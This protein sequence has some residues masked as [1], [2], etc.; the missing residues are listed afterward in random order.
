MK[1]IKEYIL[2]TIGL[3]FVA[4]GIVYFLVPNDL[5]AGGVS[6]LAMVINYYVPSLSVGT[7]MLIAN[8]VLFIVAFLL[9]GPSFGAKTIYASLGLSGIIWI[10]E[11]FFP[12]SQP[13]TNNLLLEL[14]YGILISGAGMGIVFNQNASTGGT[15][16]I[17]KILNKFFHFNIGKALLISDLVVTLGAL[18]TFGAEKGMYALLGVIINGFVIDEVIQGINMV[19]EVKIISY[20][21]EEIKKFIMDELGRGLTIYYAKG[22][23]TNE[24]KE[25]LVVLLSRR[26][27]I[28]LR[29]YIKE[30]DD[31]AFIT[32]SNVHE[33]FGEGFKSF[34]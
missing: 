9:I 14:I 12:I 4:A 8:L 10:M 22:G 26:E 16:I 13:L 34:D 24:E 29:E 32:V 31:R 2:I 28:R 19:K 3:I 6:G 7:F 25:M 21:N 17:A 23:F 27:F 15:D 33:V 1:K 11:K 20:R 18:V 5:A 30:I